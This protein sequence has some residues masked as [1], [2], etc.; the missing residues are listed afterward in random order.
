MVRVLIVDD[1]M[2]VREGIK[3]LLEDCADIEIISDASSAK[4]GLA[5]VKLLVPDIVLLDIEMPEMDGFAVAN[6]LQIQH[7]TVKIIMLSS[8]E[9]EKYVR[10][11]TQSGAK[12]YLLKNASSQDLEWAIKLVDQGY[13]AFKSELLE[14]QFTPQQ[15]AELDPQLDKRW[16]NRSSSH[17]NSTAVLYQENQSN[18]SKS[19]S[20]L[21]TKKQKVSPAN[22]N[23]QAA[24]VNQNDQRQAFLN[25]V[26]SKS[27]PVQVP[28]Y[29]FK[30]KLFLLSILF[31]CG[32]VAVVVLS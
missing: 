5:K 16:K 30:L 1:Q 19:K 17:N 9:D 8:H 21:A 26:K 24:N 13:S 18:S 31:F 10:K 29:R 20:S 2:I 4:E 3:I 15:V 25:S 12:G 6:R 28:H 27:S 14:K 11:A 32:L 23:G 7:P 22:L